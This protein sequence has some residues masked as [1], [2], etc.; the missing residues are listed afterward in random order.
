LNDTR[1]Q[2]RGKKVS[3]MGM[4]GFSSPMMKQ[5]ECCSCFQKF[6]RLIDP[7]VEHPLYLLMYCNKCL[8]EMEKCDIT[9][10][11]SLIDKEEGKKK[12][13]N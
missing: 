9:A 8:S 2:R 3:R 5:Y 13:A 12:N 6:F 1:K 10:Q 7:Q 4:K 11:I